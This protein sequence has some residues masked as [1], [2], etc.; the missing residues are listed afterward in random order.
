MSKKADGPGRDPMAGEVD[1]LLRQL[2]QQA[3]RKP[4]PVV[5]PS[6]GP[7]PSRRPAPPPIT[8]TLPS[9]LGVWLRV[10][11]GALLAAAMTQWPYP[12]RGLPLAG[13]FGALAVVAVG[14]GWAGY[15]SWRRR[16][17]AAH[18]VAIG[19]VFFALGVAALQLL[20]WMGYGAAGRWPCP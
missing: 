2:G 12:L 20:P 6:A 15:A 14:G 18:I 8:V 9:P 7:H 3:P 16:M 4:R 19:L 5:G 11:L 13:Y 10:A 17:G 1:R